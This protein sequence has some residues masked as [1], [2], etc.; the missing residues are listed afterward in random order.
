MTE[1]LVRILARESIRQ[2]WKRKKDRY[3][4]FI[5][6]HTD[7][8]KD[9]RVDIGKTGQLLTIKAQKQREISINF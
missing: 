7:N 9:K 5:P 6:R 4:E 3:E 1:L 8:I 2:H